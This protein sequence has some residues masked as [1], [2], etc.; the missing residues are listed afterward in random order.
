MKVKS[1]ERLAAHEAEGGER[2][3]GE[4]SAQTLS[5]NSTK[6]LRERVSDEYVNSLDRQRTVPLAQTRRVDDDGV[7]RGQGDGEGVRLSSLGNR[8][9]EDVV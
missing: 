9:D 1:W 4:R 2:D 8:L 6:Q 7:D 5:N 3:E